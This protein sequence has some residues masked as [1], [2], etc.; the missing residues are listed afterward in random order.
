MQ[1]E[2]HSCFAIHALLFPIPSAPTFPTGATSTYS[3]LIYSGDHTVH[4]RKLIFQVLNSGLVRV[5]L[6]VLAFLWT[7]S[8]ILRFHYN[9]F[10]VNLD[11][12]T[13]VPAPDYSEMFG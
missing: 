3:S 8:K 10:T 13:Q 12:N 2:F 5:Y 9:F 6:L 11:Y 1:K 7:H 4:G